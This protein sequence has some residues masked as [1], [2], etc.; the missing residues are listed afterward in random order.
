MSVTRLL[1]KYG[2]SITDDKVQIDGHLQALGGLSTSLG[3]GKIVYVDPANGSDLYTGRTPKQAVK[4]LTCGYDKLSDNCNDILVLIGD[5]SSISLETEL[6]WAK[7]YTHLYGVCSPV[8][9]GQRARVLNKAGDAYDT[10][11][12]GKSLLKVTGSGCIFKN[13]YFFQGADG[14]NKAYG[15]VHV[16]GLRNY[17]EN[18]H[19]A[20]MGA[21]ASGGNAAHADSY[22]LKVDGGCENLF[23]GCSI[24]VDTIKR[25]AANNHLVITGVTRRNEFV[26]CRFLSWAENNAYTIAKIVGGQEFYTLFDSCW[27]YNFWT[28]FAD[29][30]NEAFDVTVTTTHYS[31]FIN[32]SLFNIDELDAG[33]TAGTLVT[34]PATAAACGIAVTPTT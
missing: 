3:R 26:D 15:A 18:V 34:G 21:T 14:A 12:S 33:D 23:I 2:V 9:I 20:G 4:T 17:F 16:T 5:N 30:L 32:P 10:A 22:S 31:L 1:R 29:G 8:P 13:L 11:F 7:D 27:F 24:G 6:V 25:T 19:F 28:N